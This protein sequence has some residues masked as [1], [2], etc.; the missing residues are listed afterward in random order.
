MCSRVFCAP[1]AVMQ[2]TRGTQKEKKGTVRHDWQA[3][4]ARVPMSDWRVYEGGQ[5]EKRTRVCM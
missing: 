3:T 2:A 5:E 4:Y 1:T